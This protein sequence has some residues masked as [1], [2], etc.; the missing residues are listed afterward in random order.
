[1]MG[2]AFLQAGGS[3]VDVT[4]TAGVSL[5]CAL[6]VNKLI[7]EKVGDQTRDTTARDHRQSLLP[8]QHQPHKLGDAGRPYE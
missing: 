7:P 5:A 8:L 3:L 1:M 4:A 2:I 6:I